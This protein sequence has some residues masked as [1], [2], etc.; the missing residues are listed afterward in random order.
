MNAFSDCLPFD[1][2]IPLLGLCPK[3]IIDKTT[4][5]KI[6]IAV[7][8]VVAK[9]WKMMECPS[10]GEWL[11]KLWYLLVMEYYCAQR[12]KLTGEIPCELEWPPGTDAEWKEQN[13][14]NIIYRDWYTVVQWNIMDFSTSSNAMTQDNAEGLWR[15]N[16]IH[17]QRKNCGSRKT[18]E[19]Y[20]IN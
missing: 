14:E 11:N 13:Q 3:E 15:K 4:C 8:F 17:T 6:F 16:A 19:K 9:N 1:S 7:L 2:A 5:I 10:T 20:M 18:L 12:K